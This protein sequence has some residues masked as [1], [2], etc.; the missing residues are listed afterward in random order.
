MTEIE[1]PLFTKALTWIPST[2]TDNRLHRSLGAVVIGPKNEVF[3]PQTAS[4]SFYAVGWGRR[5]LRQDGEAIEHDGSVKGND[6]RESRGMFL[7]S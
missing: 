5:S 1:A 2:R 7:A 3:P 6:G 4:S